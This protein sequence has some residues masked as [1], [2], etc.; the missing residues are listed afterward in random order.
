MPR[1]RGHDARSCRSRG[2]VP[3]NPKEVTERALAVHPSSADRPIGARYF[4]V[5]TNLRGRVS[6]DG[7]QISSAVGKYE[8]PNPSRWTRCSPHAII[9]SCE[10]AAADRRGGRSWAVAIVDGRSRSRHRGPQDP[11]TGAPV[12][13]AGQTIAGPFVLYGRARLRS[14]PAARE[15]HEFHAWVITLRTSPSS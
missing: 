5:S 12:Q 2:R 1:V 10:P 4:S 3:R 11:S 8:V 15:I 14:R 6:H 7:V 13:R 9:A